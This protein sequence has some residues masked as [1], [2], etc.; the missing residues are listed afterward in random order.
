MQKITP[1]LWFEEKAQE[2]AEFYVSV[3]G[4][5]AEILNANELENTPSGTVRIIS[6]SLFGQN[7]TLMNDGPFQKFNKAISFV[8]S[9]EN[10]EE[11]DSYWNALSA[12]PKDEQCGWLNDKYGVVWQIVPTNLQELFGGP[13][14][15]KSQHVTQ[16][17]IKMKKLVIE[18]LRN[19]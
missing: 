8:V 5:N 4:S 14:K 7:F 16:A 6:L 15:E 9:C 3:F 12:S 19:A 2:A 18:E 1:F 11:I 10:Q 17:M 13:D